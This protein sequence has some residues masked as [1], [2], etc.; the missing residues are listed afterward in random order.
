MGKSAGGVLASSGYRISVEDGVLIENPGVGS[1]RFPRGV[2]C[3]DMKA[4]ENL[5]ISPGFVL[6]EAEGL[7]QHPAVV[8]LH[9]ISALYLD[10]LENQLVSA[11]ATEIQYQHKT[12]SVSFC[13]PHFSSYD[14]S[15]HL[16]SDD[17][18]DQDTEVEQTPLQSS[19]RPNASN[20]G[21]VYQEDDEETESAYTDEEEM[22]EGY[23]IQLSDSEDEENEELDY[24]DDRPPIDSV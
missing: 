23:A 18:D 1:I 24:D 3:S 17:E 22:N 21:V 2:D 16:F 15:M 8:L 12:Q 5:R 9:K 11:G 20:S 14:I 13:V 4:G 6:V 19:N 10:Q 7:H